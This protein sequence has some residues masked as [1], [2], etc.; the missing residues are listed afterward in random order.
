MSKVCAQLRTGAARRFFESPRCSVVALLARY[1]VVAAEDAANDD[2]TA[3]C[4]VNAPCCD[5]IPACRV[6]RVQLEAVRSGGLVVAEAAAACEF[7]AP[8]PPG[9][10]LRKSPSGCRMAYSG[11]PMRRHRRRVGPGGQA[12]AGRDLAGSGLLPALPG[13]L[14]AQEVGQPTGG[15]GDQPAA[16]TGWDSVGRPLARGGEQR[17]LDGV[18][19]EV[20]MPV[21]SC[22]RAEDL[23]REVAQQVLDPGPWLGHI[24]RPVRAV[25]PPAA[26][27][28]RT[29]GRG[30]ARGRGRCRAGW[31]CFARTRAAARTVRFCDW[32]RLRTICAISS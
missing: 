7:T 18:L 6:P 3:C 5:R 12:V 28:P 30:R 21:S 19:G 16:W 11:P 22:Q 20:E 32:K 10:P 24:S 31:R 25:T 29:P 2:D 23:R 1:V 26:E 27:R 14:R 13:L 17:L 4:L 8:G 15:D 9:P